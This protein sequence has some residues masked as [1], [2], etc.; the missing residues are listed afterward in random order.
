MNIKLFQKETSANSLLNIVFNAN[1]EDLV[2]Q[3]LRIHPS[4]I[5]PLQKKN[6]NVQ[7][8]N[9]KLFLSFKWP[10]EDSDD[11][12]IVYGNTKFK[13]KIATKFLNYCVLLLCHV[14][15]LEWIYTLE[16]PEC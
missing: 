12:I 6:K 9:I 10:L 14:H 1:F 16:L 2:L 8:F 7:S 5:T 13:D 15:V 4:N 3:V 11:C